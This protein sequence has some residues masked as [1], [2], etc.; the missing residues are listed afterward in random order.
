MCFM[1]EQIEYFIRVNNGLIVMLTFIVRCLML[2]FS[3]YLGKTKR[4]DVSGSVYWAYR[5]Y[6]TGTNY[7]ILENNTHCFTHPNIT[8]YIGGLKC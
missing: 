4:N 6:G 8:K 5:Y 3:T 2:K 1:E 7:W